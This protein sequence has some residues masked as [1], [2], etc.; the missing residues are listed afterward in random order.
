MNDIQRLLPRH[1]KILDLHLSGLTTSQI[2]TE[3][4]VT[5]QTVS[6]VTRSPVYQGELSR[7]RDDRN[8]ESDDANARYLLETKRR[9]ELAA[10]EALDVHINGLK[11]ESETMKHRSAEAILS[12]VYDKNPAQNSSTPSIAINTESVNL[13]IAAMGE[14]S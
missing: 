4:G 6:N 1:H 8:S 3:L 9:M 12:R 7:R 11:S 13:L 10:G 2:A 14:S 5:P